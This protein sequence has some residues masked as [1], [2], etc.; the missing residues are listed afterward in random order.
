MGGGVG[1]GGKV[2][3]V[4]LTAGGKAVTGKLRE[5][6]SSW[7]PDEPLDYTTTYT[8]KVTGKSGA[9]KNG[10]QTT[11]F[12]TMGRPGNRMEAHLYMAD[13]AT[14]GQAMPLVSGL[15]Q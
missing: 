1:R 2:K 9:G 15:K 13:N 4:E 11:T 3:W 12:T 10:T 7:G 14:D 6:G 5:D 8:A